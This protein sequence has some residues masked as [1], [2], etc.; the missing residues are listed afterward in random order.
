MTAAYHDDEGTSEFMSAQ[1]EALA[2]WEAVN[3]RAQP[4]Q[5][6]PLQ[7]QAEPGPNIE[8]HASALSYITA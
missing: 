5:V 7:G 8:A 4:L 3:E 6:R 2:T 1:L